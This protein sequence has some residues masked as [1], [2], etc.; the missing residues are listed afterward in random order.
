LQRSL[1]NQCKGQDR[2]L[3]YKGPREYSKSLISNSKLEEVEG[4]G[5]KFEP[6]TISTFVD[7]KSFSLSTCVTISKDLKLVIASM[8]LFNWLWI[9][10]EGVTFTFTTKKKAKC[11]K[12]FVYTYFVIITTF[13]NSNITMAIF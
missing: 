12:Y 4:S 10:G 2:G 1:K 9:V 11:C 3:K 7:L 8:E 5:I 13:I 6:L